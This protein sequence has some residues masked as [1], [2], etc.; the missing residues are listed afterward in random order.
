MEAEEAR[1][2]A[3]RVTGTAQKPACSSSGVTPQAHVVKLKDLVLEELGDAVHAHLAR[4]DRHLGVHC[5]HGVVVVH[6]LLALVDRALANGDTDAHMPGH[7]V[8]R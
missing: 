1:Q 5:R 3:K 4:M 8:L 7:H 6:G 2:S